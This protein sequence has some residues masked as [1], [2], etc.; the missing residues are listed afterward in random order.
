[1][2][3]RRI[4]I[5]AAAV[6]VAIVL[7]VAGF[8]VS[9]LVDSGDE[10]GEQLTPP[11]A[12]DSFGIYL[13]GRAPVAGVPHIVIWGEYQCGG[14]AGY[15]EM[16]GP[17][18]QELVSTGQITAEVR[19]AHFL[20]GQATP[21]PSARAA[22]A[23]AAADT[24]GHFDRYHHYLYTNQQSGYSEQVLREL[25][26][27]AVDMSSAEMKQFQRLYD[28]SAFADW[29]QQADQ[30]FAAEGISSTPTFVVGNDELHM[31][32]RDNDVVL[33]EANTVDF[34]SA[35]NELFNS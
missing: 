18:I 35:V 2:A 29:V 6:A 25:I 3:T 24:V 9:Q 5:A 12:S 21:G 28:T 23:A 14:C 26:P 32:D 31:Y 1:M 19:Q 4:V 8:I 33:V 30:L 34:L 11:N 7:V 27:A 15:N 22:M 10:V 16:Y 17:I 13:Q 20:D